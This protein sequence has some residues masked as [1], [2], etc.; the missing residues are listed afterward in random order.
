MIT[1]LPRGA[2]LAWWAA[3]VLC[4]CDAGLDTKGERPPAEVGGRFSIGGFTFGSGDE[5][6]GYT[7]EL[8]GDERAMRE[9]AK[10]FDRTVWEG[11]LIGA[12]LGTAVGAA[13]GGDTEDAV[14]GAIVGAG[15]GAIAGMYV[16]ELQRRYAT[17]ED[18]LE[19]MTADLH[20]ANRQ[21]E[22]LIASI[23]SVIA[24]DRRRLAGVQARLARGQATR[25][26]L[27]QERGRVWGNRRVVEKAALG[28]QDQ[29]RVFEGAIQRFQQKN[30]G[31]RTGGFEQELARYRSNLATLDRL[32]GSMVRA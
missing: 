30:P 3:L 29:Y 25:A 13:A 23:Q 24:E 31:V 10:K 26:D 6:F 4:A 12:V 28:G 27:E 16:A 14:S 15:V 11:I 22:A 8:S 5:R 20:T 7:G 2:A 19:A 1:R 21:S 9:Q 32:A 17:K 18:Q